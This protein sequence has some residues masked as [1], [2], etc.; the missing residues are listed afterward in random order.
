[1]PLPSHELEAFAAVAET[2]SF[3]EAA[4]RV[5]VTQPALSQRI[6]S[7]ERSLGLTLFVRGRR[8]ARLTD[9]GSRLLRCV[10]AQGHLEAEALADL[11]GAPEGALGGRLR[12]AAYSTV[13]HSV[14]VPALAPLLRANPLVQFEFSARQTRELPGALERGEADAVILD[15]SMGRP[16]IEEILLG[17]ERYVLVESRRFK[18]RDVYLDHDPDD[19]TTELFLKHQGAT[20]AEIRRCYLDDIHGL[21]RGAALGLGRAVVPRHLLKGGEPLKVSPG[22]KTL[23]VP[24]VLHFY[25]QPFYSKLQDATRVA[26]VSGCRKLL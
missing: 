1:M 11:G 8:E 26:L 10:Q 14:V 5:H 23:E 22:L 20:R 25:R 15:H 16:G 6:Q 9:A 24:I 17:R 3:S 2:R 4:R 19:R 12:I 7:L 13:L 18:S 21:L